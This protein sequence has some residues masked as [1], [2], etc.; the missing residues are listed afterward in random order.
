MRAPR[1]PPLVSVIVVNWNGEAYL[2]ECVDSLL[3]QTYSRVE[4]IIVD[5]ASAD[6]S[7]RLLTERYGAKIRLALNRTNLGFTGGNNTGIAVSTGAYVLLINNDAVADP[8]WVARLV[9]E[10]ETD[11]RIGMC[12]SKIVSYDDPSVI[13]SAGLLLARDGLGRGR[14][15]LE[16]DAGQFDQA[17]EVLIPSGC[18]GLYRKAMLDEIGLFDERFFMYCEDVDLGLR[19]R[20]AGWRCRYV[21]D[22]LVRHRY[23]KSAGSYSLRKVF[24]V[25]RNRVWVMLKSFP[26]AL[27]ALSLPWTAVRLWWHAYAAWRGLGGAGRAVEGVRVRSLVA[28]VLRAYL[29]AVAGAPPALKRRRS[30]LSAMEF[31]KWL[32]YYGVSARSVAITE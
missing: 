13:D 31:S 20:V 23:S 16:R 22:A 32:R 9:R 8:E 10:A 26:W 30:P 25:E 7:V 29:A 1:V 24:L 3:K 21:P 17:E 2:A 19:G 14:G 6:G 15:R 28:T 4:I 5:N 12:A 27:V 18:A 11:D